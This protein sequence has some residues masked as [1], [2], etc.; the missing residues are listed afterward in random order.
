MAQKSL[1]RGPCRS[2]RLRSLPGLPPAPGRRSGSGRA[3]GSRIDRHQSTFGRPRLLSRDGKQ[4][5]ARSCIV[6]DQGVGTGE[7]EPGAAA[8]V[9]DDLGC[10][11]Q[12]RLLGLRAP[13]SR[14]IGECKRASSSSVRPK[15]RRRSRRSRCVRRE[16]MAPT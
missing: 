7:R 5:V 13:M 10:D 12:G 3:I 9:G 8:A 2:C 1:R 16:P 11:G 4:A 6:M 15:P 14:P